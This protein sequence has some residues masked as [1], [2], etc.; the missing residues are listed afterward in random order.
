[1]KFIVIILSLTATLHLHANLSFKLPPNAKYTASEKSINTA[2]DILRT[3]INDDAN[4]LTNI[5]VKPTVC[6]PGLWN[7]LKHSPFFSKP[8]KAKSTARIPLPGGRFQEL[9]M[10]LLQ[11]EDEVSSFRKAFADLTKSQ[12][13]LAVREPN[14]D[15]FLV[16]WAVIPFD[17]INAPLLVAEGKDYTFICM[18]D[19]WNV[20]WIDEVKKLHPKKTG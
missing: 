11:S 15:E 19:K 8:P 1:M 3:H 13:Q 12:G 20:F 10:A 5:F 9:P 14:K 6:G 16:F 18:F 2:I 4:N 17:E 7:L